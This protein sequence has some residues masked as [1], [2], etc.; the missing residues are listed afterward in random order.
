MV[1]GISGKCGPN[2]ATLAEM[3]PGKGRGHVTTVNMVEPTV[4][5]PQQKVST[6]T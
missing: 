4:Q 3:V 1:T 6:A 5:D 2:A